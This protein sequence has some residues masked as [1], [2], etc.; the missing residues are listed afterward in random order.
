MNFYGIMCNKIKKNSEEKVKAL[1]CGNKQINVLLFI[2]II[3]LFADLCNFLSI[4]FR[5][6]LFFVIYVIIVFFVGIYFGSRKVGIGLTENRLVYVIFKSFGYNEKKV[7][8]IL[9]DKIRSLDVKKIFNRTYVKISFISDVGKL[10]KIKFS[11]SSKIFGF[12]K[13]EVKKNTLEIY[14]KLSE[15]QKILDKGDF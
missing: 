2:F 3:L 12:P 5:T 11:F 15:L 6:S 14:T 9:F 4:I 7:Y 1:A 10:E 8:E 13:E